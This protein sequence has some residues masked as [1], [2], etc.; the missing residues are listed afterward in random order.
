MILKKKQD[1]KQH[2]SFKKQHFDQ[3]VRRKKYKNKIQEKM[4]L[5]KVL[6][7]KKCCC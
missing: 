5:K 2:L 7:Y 6:F 3:N 1:K 4:K